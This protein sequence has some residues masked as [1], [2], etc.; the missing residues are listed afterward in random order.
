[1]DRVASEFK[2][3]RRIG[4][5]PAQAGNLVGFAN[6]LPPTPTGWT[7]GQINGLLFLR[8]WSQRNPDRPERRT[9][10]Q[11]W[12]PRDFRV[13]KLLGGCRCK[14]GMPVHPSHQ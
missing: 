8:E 14:P 5:T 2:A 13:V 4:F 10:R 1:M 12:R 9:V 3:A 7:P 11:G 6:G